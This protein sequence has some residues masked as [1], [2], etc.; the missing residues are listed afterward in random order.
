[1]STESARRQG[2]QDAAQNKAPASKW[3]WS[4]QERN[5]YEAAYNQQKARQK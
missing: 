4:H 5:A 2:Q 3:T 1:M